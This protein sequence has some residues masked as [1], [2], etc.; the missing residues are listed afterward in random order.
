MDLEDCHVKQWNVCSKES[1]LHKIAPVLLQKSL[2]L[3]SNFG[4]SQFQPLYIIIVITSFSY[5]K[6]SQ[7]VL[8]SAHAFLL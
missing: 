2:G 4:G 7:T 8:P 1:H 5:L 3:S 6:F